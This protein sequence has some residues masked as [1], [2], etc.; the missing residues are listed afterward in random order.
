MILGLFPFGG[1]GCCFFGP[2]LIRLIFLLG[3][4]GLWFGW[5][6][7]FL[8]DVLLL[9]GF[10]R[11]LRRGVGNR[12]SCCYFLLGLAAP[13]PHATSLFCRCFALYTRVRSFANALR[14]NGFHLFVW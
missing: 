3:M 6:G 7:R 9:L 14:L 5:P 13:I 10:K 11:R 4:V 12:R 1:G 8:P 2:L